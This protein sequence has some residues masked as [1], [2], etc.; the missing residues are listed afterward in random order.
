MSA[1]TNVV[2]RPG[3]SRYYLRCAVP[4][5]LRE[6]VG[7]REI[8]KS[9]G[10]AERLKARQLAAPM[11]ARLHQEFDD[12][13]R[14]RKPI[15]GDLEGATWNHYTGELEHDRRDRIALPL[16][17]TGANVRQRIQRDWRA[18]QIAEIKKDLATGETAQIEWVADAAIEAQGL[19]IERGSLEYR[20]LCHRLLRAQLE[21]LE[22]TAERDGGNWA[23][24]P[25]DPIVKPPAHLSKLAAKP[26]ETILELY[27]RFEREKSGMCSEFVWR[28]NRGCVQRLAEFVG[29]G[30]HISALSRTT[31]RDWKSELFKFPRDAATTKPFTGKSFPDIIKLNESI[32]RVTIS[33]RTINRYLG[34]VGSFATWLL[35]NGY[36]AD[37]IIR[38]QY[39]DLGSDQKRFPFADDQLKTV[40]ASPLFNACAGDGKEHKPGAVEVRDW[41]YWCPWLALYHGMRLGEIVQLLVSDVR[42]IHETWCMHITT[43]GGNGKSV[44]TKGSMRVVPLHSEI[45][46][47]GFLDY[48]KR[49]VDAGNERLFPECKSNV[50]DPAQQASRW[51][52]AYLDKLKVRSGRE[53]SF[54]SFRHNA[55]DALRAAGYG[56][57]VFGPLIGHGRGNGTATG[58]YGVVAQG[59]LAQRVEMIE[60]VRYPALDGLRAA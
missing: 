2:R 4:T 35:A 18:R 7:R 36:I 49:I 30:A 33:N 22:R 60:A 58:K 1:S 9:L 44:K 15:E 17:D 48:H 46:R 31:I 25:R 16:L 59:T 19:L 37:D 32:G 42:Q 29:E 43:E 27:A 14:R 3:S 21:A 6:V 41:R 26:G 52:N 51:F 13:R 39:L 50:R 38:G 55:I 24:E 47:L 54:H 23:G 8:W 20:D 12:L 56:D 57:D 53:Q 40:F 11:L 28:Q 45:I 10:T 5:D 34:A